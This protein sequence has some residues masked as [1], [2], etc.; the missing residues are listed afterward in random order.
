MKCAL[1]ANL[2]MVIHSLR[3]LYENTSISRE[4]RS[5]YMRTLSRMIGTSNCYCETCQ[6]LSERFFDPGLI[7]EERYER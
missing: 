4:N 1:N 2:Y 6:D 3:A 7:E 5:I